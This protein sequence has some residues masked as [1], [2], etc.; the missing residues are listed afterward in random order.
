MPNI[1]IHELGVSY[2]NVGFRIQVDFV[3]ELMSF[4]IVP[5]SI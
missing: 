2:L 3:L 4:F 1:P 5:L